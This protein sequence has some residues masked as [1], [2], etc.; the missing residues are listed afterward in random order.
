M[1]I[2]SLPSFSP[3]PGQGVHQGL[4]TNAC[5]ERGSLFDRARKGVRTFLRSKK[6]H[7]SVLLLVSLDV[8]CIF[9][10][11]LLA[12]YTCEHSHREGEHVSAELS[13]ATDALSIVTLVFSSLF[14]VEL[15]L[16][17]WANGIRS[18]YLL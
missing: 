10:E 15:G 16:T 4:D 12:L 13:R 5:E 6:G 2:E 8:S 17:I 1:S 9:A 18:V 14:M 3:D 11:F 7:Y